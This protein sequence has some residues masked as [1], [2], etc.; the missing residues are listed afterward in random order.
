[1]GGQWPLSGDAAHLYPDEYR[2]L[3]ESIYHFRLVPSSFFY[4]TYPGPQNPVSG[5]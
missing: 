3:I 2:V 1:V 4:F 5:D